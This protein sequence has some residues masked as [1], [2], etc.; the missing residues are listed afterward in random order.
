[1]TQDKIMSM[2]KTKRRVFPRLVFNWDCGSDNAY[3][4]I[5]LATTPPSPGTRDKI[6]FHCTQQM[7]QQTW[8]SAKKNNIG[9]RDTEDLSP[10]D[11]VALHRQQFQEKQVEFNK[12]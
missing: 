1:M 8:Y 5:V 11:R 2:A 9:L 4:T 12:H 7:V 10:L 3:V 6:K